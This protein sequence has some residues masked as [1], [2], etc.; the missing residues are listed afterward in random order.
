MAWRRRRPALYR[1][2][3]PLPPAR[4]ARPPSRLTRRDRETLIALGLTAVYAAAFVALLW[5]LVRW[6]GP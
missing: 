1:E 5:W 6:G 4:R 3:R 2:P